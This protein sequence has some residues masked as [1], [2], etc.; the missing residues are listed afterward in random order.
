MSTF[1]DLLKHVRDQ[2]RNLT[3]LLGVGSP[4]VPT[5]FGYEV[6]NR[7][8]EYDKACREFVNHLLE[9][10]VTVHIAHNAA[11]QA[12]AFTS[13]QAAQQWLTNFEASGGQKPRIEKSQIFLD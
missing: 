8:T 9:H 3:L 2:R 10:G 4:P 1:E 5:Q 6:I 13:P 12:M 11:S 7:Q